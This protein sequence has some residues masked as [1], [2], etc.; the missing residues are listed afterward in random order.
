MDRVVLADEGLGRVT[1]GVDPLVLAPPGEVGALA[2][3]RLTRGPVL[4][5]TGTR[6]PVHHAT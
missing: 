5:P 6:L 1:V 2:V 3:A 4:Q